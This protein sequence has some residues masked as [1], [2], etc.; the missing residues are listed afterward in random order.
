MTYHIQNKT[1]SLEQ[2]D[3]MLIFVAKEKKLY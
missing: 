2:K 1:Q 3:S